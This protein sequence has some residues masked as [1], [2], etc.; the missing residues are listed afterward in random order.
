MSAD[1]DNSRYYV[2]SMIASGIGD[3]LGYRNGSWEFCESGAAIHAEL[4]K[5][6]GLSKLK[7]SR[8]CYRHV[9]FSCVLLTIIELSIKNVF[10]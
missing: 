3:A 7:I 4:T 10:V 1:D 2:A 6:G 8:T 9:A 5:L